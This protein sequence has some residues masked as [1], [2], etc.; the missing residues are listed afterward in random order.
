[1]NYFIV[2]GKIVIISDERGRIYIPKKYIHKV[3]NEF[4]IV[5]M[6]KGRLLVPIPKNPL[7][8]LEKIGVDIPDLSLSDIKEEILKQVDEETNKKEKI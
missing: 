8:E 6:D 1:M 5:E 2:V 4:Y 7:E 3:P